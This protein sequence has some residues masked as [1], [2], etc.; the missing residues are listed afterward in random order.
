MASFPRRQFE[1]GA[2]VGPLS[3]PSSHASITGFPQEQAVEHSA[4]SL[5]TGLVYRCRTQVALLR[6]SQAPWAR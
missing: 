1:G 3:R 2:D 6:R 4:P 5:A